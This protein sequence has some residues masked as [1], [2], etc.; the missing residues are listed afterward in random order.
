MSIV[1]GSA[2][3]P[4]QKGD[5]PYARKSYYGVYNTA[6]NSG[7][8]AER[9]GNKVEFKQSYKTPVKSADYNEYKTYFIKH[10]ITPFL[11]YCAVYNVLFKKR[12]VLFSTVLSYFLLKIDIFCIL[13]MLIFNFESDIIIMGYILNIFE[14][15]FRGLV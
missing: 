6:Y 11:I 5:A 10:F 4:E 7:C 13:Y 8:S 15:W 12:K 14:K 2:A 1:R 3:V 9:P